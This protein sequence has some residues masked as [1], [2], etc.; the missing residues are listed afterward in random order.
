M[1]FRRFERMSRN[2]E[3]GPHRRLGAFAACKTLHRTSLS[4]KQTATNTCHPHYLPL[5]HSP[6]D[7]LVANLTLALFLL[8][9]D[10]EWR[11]RLHPTM[12]TPRVPLLRLGWK[13]KGHEVC[14]PLC[15]IHEYYLTVISSFLRA[16]LAQFAT[17]NPQIE[18]SVSPRPNKHPVIRAHYINGQERSICVRNLDNNQI[19]EKTHLLRDS[20]GQKNKRFK[21]PVTSLNESVRGVWSPFHGASYKI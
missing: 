8:T 15:I 16:R 21:K 3:H 2:F 9:I 10:S 12:Q 1:F 17:E 19:L 4:D 11:R 6:G 7:R 13:F 20:N 14:F 18:I 5:G